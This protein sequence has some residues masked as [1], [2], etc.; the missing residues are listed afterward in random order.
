M[1]LLGSP[2]ATL[3][4]RPSVSGAIVRV[5]VEEMTKDKHLIILKFRRRKNSQRKKGFR[6]QVTI[7]RV[8]D[9]LPPPDLQEHL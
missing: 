6:R 9:I 5:A 4:G 3:I 2:S 7:L 8:V 1:L